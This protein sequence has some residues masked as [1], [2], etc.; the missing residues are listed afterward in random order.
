MKLSP[1]FYYKEFFVSRSYPDLADKSYDREID[2][3]M[4]Q[5]RLKRL[6]QEVLQP[7]RDFI[8]KPIKITSGFRDKFLNEAV[9]GNIISDHMLAMAADITC[10]Y[11]LGEL[12]H[13]LKENTCYR[14]IIWYPKKN[15]IHCSVNDVDIKPFKHQHIIKE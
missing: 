14:Q 10:D 8:G 9:G 4:F 1:N 11:P 2:N 5:D 15:F 13:W 7:A 6:C 12:F 3:K